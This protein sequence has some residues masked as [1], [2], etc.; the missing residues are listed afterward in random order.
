MFLYYYIDSVLFHTTFTTYLILYQNIYYLIGDC[1]SPFLKSHYLHFDNMMLICG[2]LNV[3]CLGLFEVYKRKANV[4]FYQGRNES[5]FRALEYI[6]FLTV[7]LYGMFAPSFLI[8][9]F[10]G[11]FK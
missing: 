3:L 11:V 1:S 2:I 9:A 5:V 8:A 10:R 4:K 6:V 7:G